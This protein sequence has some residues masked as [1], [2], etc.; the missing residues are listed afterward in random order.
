MQERV[1]AVFSF[2]GRGS[3]CFVS[4]CCFFSLCAMLTTASECQVQGISFENCADNLYY[5]IPADP[6][7]PPPH[8]HPY[9]FLLVYYSV[10]FLF[11]LR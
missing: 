2:V 6:R 8:A 4:F 10:L 11:Y 1:G 7:L 9:E 5:F 3:L